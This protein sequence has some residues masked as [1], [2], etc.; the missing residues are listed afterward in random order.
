MPPQRCLGCPRAVSTQADTKAAAES[1]W[2]CARRSDLHSQG[3]RRPKQNILLSQL[4][5]MAHSE[6]HKRL[7]LCAGPGAARRQ[8]LKLG[9]DHSHRRMRSQRN[10]VLHAE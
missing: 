4:R 7:L 8:L 10:E 9:T 6:W 2:F 5:G 3:V 1:I